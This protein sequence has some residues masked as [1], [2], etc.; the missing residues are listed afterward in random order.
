MADEDPSTPW[1][2]HAFNGSETHSGYAFRRVVLL[3]LLG[4]LLVVVGLLRM[5]SLAVVGVFCLLAAFPWW[6]RYVGVLD[7]GRRFGAGS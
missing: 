3:V 4:L 2:F 7:D 1:W 6:R 5:W